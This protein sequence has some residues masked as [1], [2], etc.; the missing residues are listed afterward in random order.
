MHKFIIK[1]SKIFIVFVL[2]LHVILNNNYAPFL[3]NSNTL[4]YYWHKEANLALNVEE[5]LRQATQT[6]PFLLTANM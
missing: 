1:T 3:K 4:Y 5:N 2:K 6:Y